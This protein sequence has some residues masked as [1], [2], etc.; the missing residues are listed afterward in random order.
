MALTF[1]QA[2]ILR[3][4]ARQPLGKVMLDDFCLATKGGT[5][6]ETLQKL[7]FKMVLPSELWRISQF[8]RL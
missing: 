8:L 4:Q 2:G 7:K 6:E 1:W 5:Q 3:Q